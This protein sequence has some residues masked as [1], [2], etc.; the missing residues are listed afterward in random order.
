[1]RWQTHQRT[2]IAL[3]DLQGRIWAQEERLRSASCDSQK[4]SP[5]RLLEELRQEREDLVKTFER[6]APKVRK[7]KKS[8]VHR[9]RK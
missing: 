1:M 5:R 6:T 2:K 8:E 4:L 7:I 9:A 3:E